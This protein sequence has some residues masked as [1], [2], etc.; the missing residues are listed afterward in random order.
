MFV[1]AV[2][3]W[4]PRLH[5]LVA[6]RSYEPHPRLREVIDRAERNGHLEPAHE[7]GVPACTHRHDDLRAEVRDAGLT[8]RD[9]VA[10]EGIAFAL[11]DLDQRV[12][13][14]ADLDVVLEAARTVERVP[15]MLGPGSH[16]IATAVRPTAAIGPGPR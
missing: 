13:T 7:G 15:E 10:V 1:A 6:Q 14:A 16:L 5:G 11:G 3:R 4:A 8:L 9:L 12:A 2:S